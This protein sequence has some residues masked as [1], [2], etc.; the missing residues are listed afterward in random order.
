MAEASDVVRTKRVE[1]VDERGAVRVVIGL[2]TAGEEEVVGIVVRD[3]RGRDRAWLLHR[4]ASA[5]VGLDHGG[6]TAAALAVADDGEARLFLA[7]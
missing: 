1:V 4:G 7:E 2:I 3:E 5:E 6:D